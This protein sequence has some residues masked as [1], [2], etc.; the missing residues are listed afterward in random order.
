MFKKNKKSVLLNQKG[1]SLGEIMIVLVIIGGIMAI[2]LPKI[3][4]GQD[5]SK[6]SNTKMKM[7]EITTKIDEYNSECGKYPSSLSFITDDDGSCKSWAG[8]PKLKHLLKD[9]W[10]T[11]FQYEVSG[12][13]YNLYSFGADK[14]VGGSSY[15]KDVYSDS[16]VGGGE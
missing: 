9:A 6:V 12:N 11:D 5:K 13:G 3:K 15:D 2:V 14:K 4:D 7:N 10:G 8:N 16:S 1:F